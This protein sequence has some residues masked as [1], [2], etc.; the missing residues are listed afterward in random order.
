MRSRSLIE[1]A[2]EEETRDWEIY[3]TKAKKLDQGNAWW[4]ETYACKR[5]YNINEAASGYTSAEG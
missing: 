2:K 4:A 1:K 5:A 3:L